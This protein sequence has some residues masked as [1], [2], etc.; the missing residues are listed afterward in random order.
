[1]NY[2]SP[3]EITLLI[4][5]EIGTDEF[6]DDVTDKKF[7]EELESYTELEKINVNNNPFK[8]KNWHQL[9]KLS[10]YEFIIDDTPEFSGLIQVRISNRPKE[11]ANYIFAKDGFGETYFLHFDNFKHGDWRVW[12]QLAIGDKLLVA[13]DQLSKEPSR[14]IPTSE[15]YI[16]N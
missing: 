6:W 1:M 13:A 8:S 11:G 4:Y 7:V 9:S 12:C 16:Q 15:I 3:K 14:A 10:N 5:G 2:S